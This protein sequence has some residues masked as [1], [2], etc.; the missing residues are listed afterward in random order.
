MIMNL[1]YHIA[2]ISIKCP[3][4]DKNSVDPDYEVAANIGEKIVLECEDCGKKFIAEA[5][6]AY[7][8]YANC[9]LNNEKHD[10]EKSQYS[11]SVHNCRKCPEFLVKTKN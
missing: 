11:S 9:E 2:E 8:T 5:N 7:D 10:Y 3:Y 6:I 4:C 1:N